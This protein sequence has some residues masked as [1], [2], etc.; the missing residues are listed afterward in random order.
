MTVVF[1]EKTGS[2]LNT[3]DLELN[4]LYDQCETKLID[5]GMGNYI[6]CVKS[7]I[8]FLDFY[9]TTAEYLDKLD[10]IMYLETNKLSLFTLSGS[11]EFIGYIGN[12]GI[13]D[14]D[15]HEKDI[16]L[17]YVSSKLLSLGVECSFSNEKG[18]TMEIITSTGLE[19]GK[20]T[21]NSLVHQFS[22]NDTGT[23]KILSPGKISV[24]VAEAM[25]IIGVIKE[26][27]STDEY[28]GKKK[29]NI[30]KRIRQNILNRRQSNFY[31]LS[32]TS[33]DEFFL[34]S[35]DDLM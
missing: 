29:D 12:R 19:D 3:T 7:F 2:I 8:S 17:G 11:F 6:E 13:Y 25:R 32:P 5:V 30:G 16:I 15:L 22:V 27:I 35:A 10:K 21:P 4:E 1:S 18:K 23:L 33:S 26:I 31:M 20:M 24:V 14:G 28:P 9:P 34:D